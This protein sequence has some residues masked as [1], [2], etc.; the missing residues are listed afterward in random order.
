MLLLF[1]L[2]LN[3]SLEPAQILLGA[4]LAVVVPLLTRPLQP[5][6]YPRV[7][8]PFLL[9]RLLV[10]ALIEIIRSCFNVSWLILSPRRDKLN[11]QFIRIPLDI[12]NPYGLALLSC[13]INSTPG[14]VWVEILPDNYELSLHVFD[15]HDE[16]WWINTIKTQ[17]EKPLIEIF[18]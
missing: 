8:K 16:Q 2:L 6:A 13:L 11:S 12:R 3:E 15:L 17:Y 4:M 14:T 7:A 18:K 1:W 5:L 10:M 9:L